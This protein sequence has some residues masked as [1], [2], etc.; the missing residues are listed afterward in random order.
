MRNVMNRSLLDMQAQA[1]ATGAHMAVGQVRKYTNEP[2]VNHCGEVADLVRSVPHDQEMIAAA[3]LH[4]TVEDT[5]VTQLDIANVFGS[6]VADLVYWLT[7]VSQPS[8]GNREKR[9]AMDREHISKAPAR[10]KTIK[11][12]DMIS[13]ARNI[14]SKDPDFAVVYMRE[15]W[16][17]LQSPL[18]GGDPVLY[19]QAFEI[20]REYFKKQGKLLHEMEA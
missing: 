2:Y 18:V 13:N 12:A 8:D 11:L 3:W 15:K 10:A 6:N 4:D 16:K 5:K 17:L 19:D 14:E 20:V 1:F 9:K 7:D